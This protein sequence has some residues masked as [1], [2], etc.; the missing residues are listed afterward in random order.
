MESV[1]WGEKK[2]KGLTQNIS[3]VRTFLIR[4]DTKHQAVES[5]LSRE[6]VRNYYQVRNVLE[7]QVL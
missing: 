3:Q 2:S 5:L 1:D 7:D 4:V 6:N